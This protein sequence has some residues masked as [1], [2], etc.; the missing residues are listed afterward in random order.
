MRSQAL[1]HAAGRRLPGLNNPP[2]L[3]MVAAVT[4][5]AL[6]QFTRTPVWIF[7]VFVALAAWRLHTPAPQLNAERRGGS[8]PALLRLAVGA[9]IVGGVLISYGTLTGRDAG[10]AL[11][12]LLAAMKLVEM[13]NVRDYYIAGYIGLFLVLTNFFYFQSM[14][15]AI[16]LALCVIAF[17]SAFISFNDERHRLGSLRRL[18]LAAAMLAQAVP[19]MLVLFVLFPRVTGPLWGLPRDAR[20][21]LTGLDDEMT[22]GAISALT[23]SDEVAFR[24]EFSGALPDHSLLYWRGPVLWYTD[25]VKW[26]PDRFRLEQPRIQTRGQPVEYT[27]TMEPTERNSLFGLELPI[28]APQRGAFSHDMQ[29]RTRLPVRDRQ[30]YT[31]TSYPDYSLYASH[32][33]EL[34]NALQLPPGRHPRAVTLARDWRDEG[35]NERQVVARAL[36]MFNRQAFY[37]TLSPPRLLEDTI[38]QFLF[39][40]RQGFCEHY[41]AAF[42][43]LMRAA[44]IPARVVT[45]Y[46]GGAVNPI[47]NYLIVRQRDAHAWT[48]VW[49][50]E[51]GWTRVDPTAAVAPSRIM[52]GIEE[53]LPGSIIDIP[54]G[55]QDNAIARG[56]W[57]QAGNT[58]DALNNRWNQWVL[59]Y[60]RN[61]Q[62]TFLNRLGLGALDDSDLIV[63][64]TIAFGALL[65]IVAI[66]LFRGIQPAGDEARRLHDQFCK[67]LARRG[68]VRRPSE[69]PDDFA[70]RA[71]LRLPGSAA[72][73]HSVTD[74]YVSVRYAGLRE[75]LPA[76][77]AAVADFRPD[78][79][80]AL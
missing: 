39:E 20:S 65:I 2:L 32:H 44:G 50:G 8:P 79:R 9:G 54:L 77:R 67:K 10:V 49:L 38:D 56:L 74:L 52:Q 25:G 51:Q 36:K 43:I 61:R 42:V 64:L 17:L 37:Y 18:R 21:G 23:L 69:G 57:E 5:A 76:L 71:G 60:D 35:L 14:L 55:L 26:V 80:P 66:G 6:P 15:S 46:Q 11:L 12:I 34:I 1:H 29:I 24:V 3:S 4:L 28:A 58:W 53:A 70:R 22:P 16:Y 31:M 68:L 47:G 48:E 27:V 72:A 78:A 30:R 59:G 62:S 63:T 7:V 13:R 40:T 73:M 41:A 19:L 33:T 75:Q 45:G